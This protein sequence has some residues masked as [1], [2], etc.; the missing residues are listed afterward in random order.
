MSETQAPSDAKV[1][2]NQLLSNNGAPYRV[3]ASDYD[4]ADKPA[5]SA[6]ESGPNFENVKVYWTVG[7][8][9]VTSRDV[10]YETGI[11]WYKLDWAELRSPF[12]YKLTIVAQDTYNYVFYD[13]TGDGYTLGVWQGARTHNVEYGSRKPTIVSISGP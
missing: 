4:I 12:T 11:T 6:D 9:G 2:W 10:Q 5:D 3:K 7:S 8:E 1:G 13:E